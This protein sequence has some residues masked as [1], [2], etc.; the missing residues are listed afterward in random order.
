MKCTDI[1]H[2]DHIC[3]LDRTRNYCITHRLHSE[4]FLCG[5]KV[6]EKMCII[7]HSPQCKGWESRTCEL[8]GRVCPHFT[9]RCE[10]IGKEKLLHPNILI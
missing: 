1:E 2:S 5:C 4:H 10:I 6:Y 9:C 3:G 7:H 8:H